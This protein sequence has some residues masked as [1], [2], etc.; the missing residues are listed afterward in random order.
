M[1]YPKGRQNRPP[2]S[3][4]DKARV[5]KEFWKGGDKGENGQRES[6]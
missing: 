2:L 4:Y 5:L 6:I 3:D 1:P